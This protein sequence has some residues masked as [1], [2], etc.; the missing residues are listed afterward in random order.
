MTGLPSKSKPE[1]ILQVQK[2]S[3]P[4]TIL[5]CPR[6]NGLDAKPE[7]SWR[8]HFP[9]LNLDSDVVRR[10]ELR[11][12]FP[13][14]LKSRFDT[15]LRIVHLPFRGAH[16]AR[17]CAGIRQESLFPRVVRIAL[18]EQELGGVLGCRVSA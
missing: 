5:D 12:V 10:D 11:L 1:R 3:V 2:A 14:P 6:L 7:K 16:V 13:P 4:V 8:L 9:A 17:M 18:G 15:I